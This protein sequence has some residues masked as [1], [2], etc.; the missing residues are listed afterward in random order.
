MKILAEVFLGAGSN[1]E[2][3]KN[4]RLGLDALAARFSL[5]AVSDVYRSP[6]VGFSGQDFLNL[7]LVLDTGDTGNAQSLRAALEEIHDLAGRARSETVGSR[8]LDLDLL[9]VGR[10]VDA[11]ERL[12][13]EDILEYDFV[14]GPMA[15]IAPRWR[16]PVTGEALMDAWRCRPHRDS[17][18]RL[19][20][21]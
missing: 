3:A 13:R 4:L 10:R 1:I 5:G 9:S 19:G 21:L 12:P 6:P 15:E 11:T 2:P 18:K 16:H 17:L 8:T 7:V 14:L 20:P